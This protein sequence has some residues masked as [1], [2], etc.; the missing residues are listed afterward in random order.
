LQVSPVTCGADASIDDL[1][2]NTIEALRNVADIA[3][4]I[5]HD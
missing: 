5:G 4:T 1:E 2:I 3:L